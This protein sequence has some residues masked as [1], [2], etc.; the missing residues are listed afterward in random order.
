MLSGVFGEWF[1][2]G[3]YVDEFIM[4]FVDR[5]CLDLFSR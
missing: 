3:F 4:V 1:I 5:E 2:L